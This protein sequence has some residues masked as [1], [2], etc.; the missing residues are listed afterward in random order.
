MDATLTI[1]TGG[2]RDIWVTSE[3][4]QEDK[5]HQLPNSTQLAL[6]CLY[7]LGFRV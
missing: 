3:I 1:V 6:S 4:T 7:I 2:E 5:T